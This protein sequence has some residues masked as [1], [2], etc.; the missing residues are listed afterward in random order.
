M[1]ELKEYY[2]QGILDVSAS[3]D[4]VI[5]VSESTLEN[6][7]IDAKGYNITVEGQWPAT[8][9]PE[10]NR[11][12][13][14]VNAGLVNMSQL[15]INEDM[16]DEQAWIGKVYTFVAIFD[17]DYNKV[18]FPAGMTPNWN[19]EVAPF[20]G[21]LS[22]GYDEA[23]LKENVSYRGPYISYEEQNKLDIAN[24]TMIITEGDLLED[25]IDS[26]SDYPIWTNVELDIGEV[27][28]P[29]QDYQHITVKPGGSLKITGKITITGGRLDWSVTGNGQ[30]DIS[31]VTLVK[32]HPSPDMMIIRCRGFSDLDVSLLQPRAESGIIKFS[33]SDE[34]YSITIWEE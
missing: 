8:V 18:S 7:R 4:I 2:Q 23:E 6:M 16:F 15:D 28:L 19:P 17:T 12:I 14:I 34:S 1:Q 5:D 9:T 20:K 25:G 29:N 31:G 33:L 32:R 13:E 11:G 3:G 10:K 21:F 30:L 27:V 26:K 22:C 24:V